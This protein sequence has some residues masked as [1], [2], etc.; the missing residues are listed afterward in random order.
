[1]APRELSR[2]LESPPPG[3][4]AAVPPLHIYGQSAELSSLAEI[5]RAGFT[6]DRGFRPLYRGRPTGSLGDIA[7]FSFYPTK[8]LGAL[9]DGGMVVTNEP[10]LAAALHE[11]REYGWRERFYQRSQR[12]QL[13]SRCASGG[14]SSGSS[15]VLSRPTMRAGRRSPPAMMRA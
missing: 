7:C 8:N 12:Y 2:A 14:R 10:A 11:L 15:S 9:G 6:A 13:A 3:R 4:P 5:A 1:M